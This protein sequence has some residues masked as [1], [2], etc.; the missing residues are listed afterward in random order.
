MYCGCLTG[1]WKPGISERNRIEANYVNRWTA[2]EQARD[3]VLEL[4]ERERISKTD[5][6]APESPDVRHDPTL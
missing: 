4:I 3:Q 5:G 2:A 6:S 1:R